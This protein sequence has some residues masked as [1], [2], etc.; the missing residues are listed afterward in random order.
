MM[1]DDGR[2]R[3]AR[4]TDALLVYIAM[5]GVVRAAVNAESGAVAYTIIDAGIDA[6]LQAR[7]G[8]DPLA[9]GI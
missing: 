8:I 3:A 1:N 2:S 7:K 4:M 6:E 5:G 9:D